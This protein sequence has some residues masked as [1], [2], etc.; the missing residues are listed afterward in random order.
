MAHMTT[1]ASR[2]DRVRARMEQLNVDA[3]LLSLSADLP[4]LTGYTA[5]PLERLTMLVLPR[6]GDA[7]L[8]IPRLEAPRVDVSKSSVPFEVIGWSDGKSGAQLVAD[9]VRANCGNGELRIGF[10]DRTWAIFLLE[11]QEALPNA[12]FLPS[13]K[14]ISPLRMRKDDAELELLREAS[15]ANDR[16]A[17][18]LFAGE[19]PL[20]GRTEA[21]V[22]AAVG[23]R[24]LQEGHQKVNFSIVAAGDNAAS[25]H[26]DPTDRVIKANELVLFDFGGTMNGY[27]SDMTRMVWTGKRDNIPPHINDAY[28]ALK[29]SQAAGLV[30][31]T[32]GTPCI[33]VDTACRDVLEAAGYGEYFIHRT[34]HGIGLEEH[35]DPYMAPG[36]EL[37][38][39]PGF[40]YSVEP[41]I[42]VTGD[43]GMRLEDLVIATVD[44]PEPINHASH[45][46]GCVEA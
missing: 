36:W 3:L 6:E 40:A 31:G 39:E 41:G 8:V 9:H 11:I 26:H 1:S 5:M 34:G 38:I 15:R 28:E 43:F 21:Q 24:I 27:C 35:E 22:S 30:A 44:G 25:P 18:A 16:V 46:I 42:Y 17:D 12:T 10:D 4:W 19:I 29:A 45:E 32:I 14:V 20:I 23:A 33:D 2:I 7:I 13:S 37:G